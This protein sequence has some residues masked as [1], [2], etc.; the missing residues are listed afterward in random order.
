LAFANFASN[1]FLL[2]IMQPG[3]WQEQDFGGQSVPV[4]GLAYYISPPTS[5][6]DIWE[7]PIHA[8]IYVAF[9]LLFGA[10]LLLCPF[11]CT[12]RLLSNFVE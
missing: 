3:Q 12:A 4:G 6:S 1:A 9:V 5:F 11:Y 10:E 2:I 8:L 7:D